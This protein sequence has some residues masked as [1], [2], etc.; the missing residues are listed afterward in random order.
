MTNSIFVLGV[1]CIAML[2][3][4]LAAQAASVQAAPTQAEMTARLAAA[5]DLL[6]AMGG[7]KSVIEQIDRVIP[8]QMA[9]LQTQFPALTKDTR[10]L[11]ERSMRQEMTMGVNQLLNQMATAWSRR[12]TAADMRQIAAFHRSPA[13]VRLRAEQEALQREITEIGRQWGIDIGRKLQER[14]D[15]YMK[16]PKALTS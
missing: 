10:R 1:T 16:Q 14:L 15:D 8:A 3:A 12:F 7:R 4:P 9:A 5:H 13:G 6:E 11:I 2:T